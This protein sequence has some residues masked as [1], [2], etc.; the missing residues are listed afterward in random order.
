MGSITAFAFHTH[1][2]IRQVYW[3]HKKIEAQRYEA[4]TPEA[5]SFKGQKGSL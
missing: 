4:A 2:P 3:F 5:C 1:S